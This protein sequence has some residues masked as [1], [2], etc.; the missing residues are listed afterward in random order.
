MS[1]IARN[2][3]LFKLEALPPDLRDLPHCRHPRSP[4]LN[5]K[6]GQRPPTWSGPGVGAQVASLQSLTLRPGQ[7]HF[8]KGFRFSKACS[9]RQSG[10]IVVVDREQ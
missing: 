1:D 9:C 6:A 7:H 10:E 8:K 3:S 2:L 4:L 5:R